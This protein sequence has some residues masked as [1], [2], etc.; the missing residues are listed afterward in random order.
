MEEDKA[1]D[2]LSFSVNINFYYSISF[3]H[4][5]QEEGQKILSWSPIQTQF[6][7]AFHLTDLHLPTGLRVGRTNFFTSFLGQLSPLASLR[8]A[9]TDMSNEEVTYSTLRFLPSPSESQNRLRPGGTQRPDKGFSVPWHLIAVTLG[10]FC[11][12][13]LMAVTVL[14]TKIFQYFQE[15]HQQEEILRNL[16]QKYHIMRNDYYIK[17]QH[18]TNKSLEYDIFKNET[19][20]QKKDLDLLF[21]E[22]RRCHRKNIFSKSLQNTGKIYED[23]WSCCGAKCYYF[24]TKNQDW[25]ECKQ[26]CQSCSW[27]LLKLHD[28][29]ELVFVQSQAY[30]NNYWIG[31]SYNKRESKW[32]WIDTDMSSGMSFTLMSLPFGKGE[33]AFLSSTRVTTIDCSNTYKCIC[34][35]RI[36]FSPPP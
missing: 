32:K 19:L 13:L 22:K 28:E 36:I 8:V 16:S 4:F 1:Y 7:S 30:Q 3:Y 35:K 34:E 33:C 10:I 9:G 18:L 6:I 17:E 12:L 15:K 23:H 20:Q 26:T 14:G 25:K 11:L 2:H 21:R 31:L 29:D 5:G 27:S 24:T